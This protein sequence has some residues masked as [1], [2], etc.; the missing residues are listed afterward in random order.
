MEPT[1][2]EREKGILVIRTMRRDD[3]LKVVDA[4]I[5]EFEEK[6]EAYLQECS[7]DLNNSYAMAPHEIDTC[8]KFHKIY[9]EN[10]RNML[11]E[12]KEVAQKQ[13]DPRYMVSATVVE[14][15]IILSRKT[16]T[17]KYGRIEKSVQRVN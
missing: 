11:L 14:Q 2:A 8:V 10:L 5:A 16:S 12:L 4:K 15:L 17:V 13:M 3:F 1:F 6:A 9:I 7:D